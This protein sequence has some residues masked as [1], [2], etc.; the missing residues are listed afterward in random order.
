[1]MDSF[2]LFSYRMDIYQ[3]TAK[4]TK[5]MS[6]PPTRPKLWERDIGARPMVSCQIG[7]CQVPK[8]E[9]AINAIKVIN[10]RVLPPPAVYSVPDA[11]P[12]PS[13]MPRPNINAPQTT[14]KFKGATEPLRLTPNNSP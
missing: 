2:R 4:I 1:M 5:L 12:P 9:P 10:I 8:T 7:H 11:H 3:I 6:M 13:C 14:E